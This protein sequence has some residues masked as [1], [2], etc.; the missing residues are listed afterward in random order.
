MHRSLYGPVF[1]ISDWNNDHTNILIIA[2]HSIKALSFSQSTPPSEES[3]SEFI[4]GTALTA[5]VNWSEGYSLACNIMFSNKSQARGFREFRLWLET[6]WSLVLWS[7]TA[8][9]SFGS[10][11]WVFFSSFL[12]YLNCLYL[13]PGF[14]SHLFFLFSLS[15]CCV[16]ERGK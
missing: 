7:V 9:A 6:D 16:W 12:C 5:D 11:A 2:K 1:W 10:Y 15:C 14:F 3:N 13:N 4:L 8:S